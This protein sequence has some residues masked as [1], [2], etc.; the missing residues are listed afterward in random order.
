MSESRV[1][2]SRVSEASDLAGGGWRWAGENWRVGESGGGDGWIA[3]G[4]ERVREREGE[5]DRQRERERDEW[6]QLDAEREK[7]ERE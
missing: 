2:E 6:G 7:E 5:R 1:S 3:E 4:R